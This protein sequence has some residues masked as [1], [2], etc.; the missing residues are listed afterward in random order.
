MNKVSFPEV[1]PVAEGSEIVI[2]SGTALAPRLNVVHVQH[3]TMLKCRT[4]TAALAPE[5]VAVHDTPAHAQIREPPRAGGRNRT[6]IGRWN[7]SFTICVCHKCFEGFAP[8]AKTPL[9]GATG[10]RGHR[11]DHFVPR[12]LATESR[13]HPAQI[14]EQFEFRDV[15]APAHCEASAAQSA[16]PRTKPRFED[17]RRAKTVLGVLVVSERRLPEQF[18][19]AAKVFEQLLV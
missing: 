15:L 7:D 9:V 4:S 10:D 12:W 16:V 17:T 2:Q 5:A 1:T 6:G 13:P 8:A 3:D 14:L 18:S 11:L 19:D